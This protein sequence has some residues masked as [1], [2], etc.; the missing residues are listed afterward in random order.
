VM[1]VDDYHRTFSFTVFKELINH[2]AYHL[3]IKGGKAPMV[4]RLVVVLSNTPPDQW[5]PNIEE[6]HQLAVRR[7]MR[8]PIGKCI[9]ILTNLVEH[10]WNAEQQKYNRTWT[11]SQ[12]VRDLRDFIGFDADTTIATNTIDGRP[13]AEGEAMETEGAEAEGLGNLPSSPLLFETA[14]T[15][16]SVDIAQVPNGDTQEILEELLRRDNATM[17]TDFYE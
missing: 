1:I 10:T 6:A 13:V 11:C 2:T 8:A 15:H 9:N 7:R 4:A 5:Y 16:E 14:R 12:V 17:G 3:P